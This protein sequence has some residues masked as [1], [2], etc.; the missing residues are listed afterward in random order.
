[1]LEKQFSKAHLGFRRRFRWICTYR[2]AVRRKANLEVTGEEKPK[3]RK[4]VTLSLL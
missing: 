3:T 4:A 2:R 1:M